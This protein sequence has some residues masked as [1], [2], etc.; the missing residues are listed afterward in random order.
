MIIAVGKIGVGLTKRLWNACVNEGSV[1]EDCRTGLIC[2]DGRERVMF[3]D[4]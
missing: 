2:Q 3:R 4:P 1:P